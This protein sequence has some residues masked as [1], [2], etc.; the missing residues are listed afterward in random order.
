MAL[1]FKK[2]QKQQSKLRMSIAGPSGSGK[3]FTALRI[4]T[5]MGGSIAVIDTEKGSAAKYSDQFAFDVLEM[6]DFHPDRYIEAIRAAERAGYDILIIDST[7][8]EWAGKNGI[9]ELHEAAVQ[10]QRVK[11]TYTAWAEVTP[12]HNAFINAILQANCHVIATVRSK[13]DYVQEKNERGQTE[14]RKVGMASIQREGMDYEYDIMIEMD[15]N[16]TGVVTKTRCNELDGRTFRKPGAEIA[17]IL[18]RWLSGGAPA[19]PKV[20]PLE[21][22]R[23]ELRSILTEQG[24]AAKVEKWWQD[25]AD[26]MGDEGWLRA[27]LAGAKKKAQAKESAFDRAAVIS[28]LQDLSYT[29]VKA[30][31][32]TAGDLGDMSTLDDQT[33]GILLKDFQERVADLEQGAE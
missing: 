10:K 5:E 31:D 15:V 1:T 4:A 21:P 6:D 19:T 32:T 25:N 24:D 14:I 11:N 22:L 33:L 18:T 23:A 7:T 30:G 2:A 27:K 8:H 13:T 26:H 28:Q 12:L 17:E 20:D 16:H 9:L 3:T 29:L